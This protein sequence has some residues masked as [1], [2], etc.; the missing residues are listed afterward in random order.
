MH[1]AMEYC[2]AMPNRGW[3]LKPERKWDGKDKSFQF[4][5]SCMSDSDYAKCLV[6]RRSVSGYSTFFE[7]APTTVKSAIQRIVAL[8]D[9][10]AETIAGVQCVQD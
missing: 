5:I 10:K 4:R 3:K 2:A 1:Q 9:T 7:G 6:T 8:S